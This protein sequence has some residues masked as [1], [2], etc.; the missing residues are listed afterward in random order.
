MDDS[1]IIDLYWQRD[2]EAITQTAQKY[3]SYCHSIS[4]NIL[5]CYRNTESGETGCVEGHW[6]LPVVLSASDVLAPVELGI[7]SVRAYAYYYWPV[8]FQLPCRMKLQDVSITSADITYRC[9]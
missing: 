6:Q 2:E 5:H 8:S 1:I 7:L 3:G 9:D 4:F